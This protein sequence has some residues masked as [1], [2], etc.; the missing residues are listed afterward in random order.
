[1]KKIVSL[2]LCLV[3]LG[4]ICAFAEEEV[5]LGTVGNARA[6]YSI[7]CLTPKQFTVFHKQS[8]S[9][10]IEGMLAND[11]PKQASY[12]FVIAMDEEYAGIESLGALDA[13]ELE[14]RTAAYEEEGLAVTVKE[15]NGEK[16][17][18][19]ADKTAK[20]NTYASVE[21]VIHGCLIQISL[22]P[23]EEVY[24]SMTEKQAQAAVD[25]LSTLT[26]TPAEPIP[27]EEEEPET[28]AEEQE[29][30]PEEEIAAELPEEISDQESDFGN[31]P[32]LMGGWAVNQEA[33]ESRLDEEEQSVFDRVVAATGM[34]YEPAAVL[35]TQV[36]A[37]TNY[38]YLCR[39]KDGD[40]EW[41][42]VTVYNGLNG[43]VQVL[44]A[45]VL[46]LYNLLTA[47][48]A[49]PAGLSGGWS[50]R[51]A[52]NG[53]LLQPEEAQAAFSQAVAAAEE[54]LSPIA[55]LGT[56]VVAGIN[57]KVLARGEN[58]LYIVTVYAP[59]TGDA[60]I[61]DMEMLDLLAYVSVN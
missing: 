43:E 17:L 28:G 10:T 15:K 47:E 18:C 6:A 44:N 29:G 7:S 40:R 57:Y 25:F 13:S 3:M 21:T 37:G 42:V 50:L 5:S 58:A 60:S 14:K 22:S 24:S 36:V 30:I 35:A 31:A 12:L 46:A 26:F 8:D 9:R 61:T 55:L 39:E 34:D 33:F 54:N 2:L 53:A 38:A 19:L 27:G 48:N 23:V 59:L 16:Y 1:M 45:H 41:I 49:L 32:V 52:D 56:Q 4:G 51:E 11:K 20:K